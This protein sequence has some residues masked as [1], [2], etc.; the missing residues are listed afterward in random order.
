MSDRQQHILL[1]FE[2]LVS[3]LVLTLRTMPVL[4]RVIAVAVEVAL[5]AQYTS[6]PRLGVRQSSMSALRA[7][8]PSDT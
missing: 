7:G 5:V 3:L 1:L 4:T 2:P 6:P 8:A